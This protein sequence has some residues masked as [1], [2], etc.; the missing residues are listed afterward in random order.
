[1]GKQDQNSLFEFKDK[2]SNDDICREQLF[3]LRWPNGFVCPK[4][5]HTSY[6]LIRTRNLYECKECHY[7]ASV[8]AGTVLEKTRVPLVKWFWAIY[9]VSTD[10]RGHSALALQEEINVSYKTAWYM[11]HRIRTAMLE[12]DWAYQLSG[13]VEVDECYIGGEDKSGKRGR[14]T[15]KAKVMVGVSLS[16]E[17]RPRFAKIEMVTNLKADTV[18][19]FAEDNITLGSVIRTDGFRSYSRISEKGYEHI[20]KPYDPDEDPE[21]LHW[22]H[23]IISNAKAFV[24]GTFHGLDEKH[25]QMYLA[26][27]CYRF[28][29][30]FAP[31]EIFNR[32]LSACLSCA[33]IPYA[34][35]TL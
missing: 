23:I 32:L 28:N 10:K 21:H 8:T 7:Q 26:E 29:R 2:Y 5:G 27:F 12:K 20:S 22:T 17:G 4:C 1:M 30:R 11:L 15:N 3:H 25:L 16:D 6:S 34:E 14:G 19:A 9:F 18:E 13:N 24:G 35:L 31:K 33:K